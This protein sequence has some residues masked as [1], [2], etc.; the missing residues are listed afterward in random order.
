MAWNDPRLIAIDL[1]YADIRPEKGLYHR[2]ASAGRIRTLVDSET[3]ERAADQPPRTP[4]RG[5]AAPPCAATR[6]R[7]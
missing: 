2:L 4:V 7:W 1:Q 3:I 6:P 5:S